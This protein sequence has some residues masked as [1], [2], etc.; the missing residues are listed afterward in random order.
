MNCS[1]QQKIHHQVPKI[2]LAVPIGKSPIS[3]R[4][5]LIE[6]LFRIQNAANIWPAFVNCAKNKNFQKAAANGE[7]ISIS[8][9][10]LQSF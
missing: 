10:F 6:Q 3:Y 9:H 8:S 4:T 7:Q 1:S 5:T 2:W